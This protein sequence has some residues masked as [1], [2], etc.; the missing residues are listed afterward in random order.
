[1]GRNARDAVKRRQKKKT[2]RA[3]AAA[4]DTRLGAFPRWWAAVCRHRGISTNVLRLWGYN[5]VLLD[6]LWDDTCHHQQTFAQSTPDA[7]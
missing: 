7:E 3:L 5:A 2:F 6:V 4:W 1:M